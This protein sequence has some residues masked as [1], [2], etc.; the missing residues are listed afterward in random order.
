M[1]EL[2]TLS[3]PPHIQIFFLFLRSSLRKLKESFSPISGVL[4]GLVK[5]SKYI[6]K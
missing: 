5:I 3:P 4:Q 6:W 1:V 2:F